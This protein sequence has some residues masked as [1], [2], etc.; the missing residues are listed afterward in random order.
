M[1]QRNIDAVWVAIWATLL[2]LVV[3]LRDPFRR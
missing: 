1:A 3:G 2:K